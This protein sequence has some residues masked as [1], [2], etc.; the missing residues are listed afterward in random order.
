MDH[1]DVKDVELDPSPSSFIVGG[2]MDLTSLS[3]VVTAA[4]VS[5]FAAIKSVIAVVHFFRKK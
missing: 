5:V 3:Q 2:F 4:V 1:W